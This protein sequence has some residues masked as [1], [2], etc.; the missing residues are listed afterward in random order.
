[1]NN[2]SFIVVACLVLILNACSTDTVKPEPE[3]RAELKKVNVISVTKQK[4][5]FDINSRFAWQTDLFLA[6]DEAEQYR[7]SLPQLESFIQQDFNRRGY[8]FTDN[9]LH[10]D[11]FL[12]GVLLLE[13]HD[14]SMQH[15]D[16][17]MA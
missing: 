3:A 7:S 15:G 17:L 5:N 1:M 8:Q 13:G 6:G 16:L 12:V 4:I 9:L 14:E 11:Y 2:V 10:A